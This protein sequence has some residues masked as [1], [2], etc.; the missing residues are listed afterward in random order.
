VGEDGR[1]VDII[2]QTKLPHE[3]EIA[4]LLTLE[5]AARAIETMQ[6]RGAPLIGATA[7]YGICLALQHDASDEAL[8][9]A[10]ERLRRTRP[11]AINLNWA[12]DEMLAAVRN[13]PRPSGWRRRMRA[14]R[15]SA[16]PM[17]RP[18]GASASTV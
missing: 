5:D 10:C 7:A 8:E 12:L 15:R 2:D 13:R 18:T 1:S 4:T 17:S 6:V 14:P 3:F 11:T 9:A 16:R